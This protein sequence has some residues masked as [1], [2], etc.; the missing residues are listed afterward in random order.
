MGYWSYGS[1]TDPIIWN[2]FFSKQWFVSILLY[3][4]TTWRLTKRIE[5]KLDGNCTGTVRAMLNK[6]WKKHPMKK[7]LFGHLPHIFKTIQ[8]RR[9]RH[10][11]HS[12][13]S[14]NDILQWISSDGRANFDR[15]T[16]TYNACVLRQDVI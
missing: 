1:L 6:S 11:V 3:G 2:A 16:I 4:C 10:A 7:Q 13:R 8:I 12:W 5:K 9:T 15:P 14:I